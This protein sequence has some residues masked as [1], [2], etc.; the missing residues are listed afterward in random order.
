MEV[1]SE[2]ISW[3]SFKRKYSKQLNAIV[4]KAIHWDLSHVFLAIF[5]TETPQL[6]L[7]LIKIISNHTKSSIQA[8][9]S[10]IRA[11]KLVVI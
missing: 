9:G 5:P 7:R 3:L 10:P 1:L 2:R 4:D 6:A 11:H 8:H